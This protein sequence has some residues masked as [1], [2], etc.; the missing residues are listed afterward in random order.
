MFMDWITHY[1][2]DVNFP[3]WS[4][5]SFPIKA[6]LFEITQKDD[7]DICVKETQDLR[8]AKKI[9]SQNVGPYALLASKNYE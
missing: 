4:R 5:N 2:K 7:T 8:I 6:P 9:L 1:C 3:D